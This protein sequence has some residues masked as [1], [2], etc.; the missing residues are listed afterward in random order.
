MMLTLRV[1]ACSHFLQKLL[2]LDKVFEL[3][4]LEIDLFILVYIRKMDKNY[5]NLITHKES[6]I[7]VHIV[8]FFPYYARIKCRK[9]T[10]KC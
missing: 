2:Y 7:F 4:T 5:M 1:K 9:Y 8:H 6:W 10:K 3:Q